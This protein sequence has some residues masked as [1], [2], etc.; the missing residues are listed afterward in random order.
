MKSAFYKKEEA[1]AEEKAKKVVDA[2]ESKRIKYLQTICNDKNFQKYII[3]DIIK[4]NIESLNDLKSLYQVEDSSQ[5][6]I[7]ERVVTNV[8]AA[9]TL[10]NIL[11][12]IVN[13]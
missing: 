1:E 8:K 11:N 12:E 2:E 3:D 10:E 7:A 13:H 4:R 9:K 5:Q 6:S